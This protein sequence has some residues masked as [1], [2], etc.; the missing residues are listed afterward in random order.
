[1]LFL[2][3]TMNGPALPALTLR[4]V[5]ARTRKRLSQNWALVVPKIVDMFKEKLNV[6][7]MLAIYGTT[8][9]QEQLWNA[10]MMSG[11]NHNQIQILITL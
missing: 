6:N 4:P 10:K 5:N 9:L 2:A 7:Q 8:L 1:M 3:K 11:L